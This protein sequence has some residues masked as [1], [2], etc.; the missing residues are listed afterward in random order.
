M[1]IKGSPEKIRELCVQTSIPF[2]YLEK[3]DILAKEGYRI[4]ALARKE[5]K[6]KYQNLYKYER[7]DYEKNFIFQGFLV[8]EN[9]I[10]EATEN[11]IKTLNRAYI[12]TIMITGDN[13]LT[14]ISVGR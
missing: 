13:I 11:S 4:I 10:K 14:A 6:I 8:F 1:F 2:N 3:L 12:R 9:K 7:E 5:I